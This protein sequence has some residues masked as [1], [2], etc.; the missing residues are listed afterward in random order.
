MCGS[1]VSATRGQPEDENSDAC[2][3]G[4]ST[5]KKD[6]QVSRESRAGKDRAGH[7]FTLR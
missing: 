3:Y 7:G 2:V 6:Q 5:P 4:R 1:Q